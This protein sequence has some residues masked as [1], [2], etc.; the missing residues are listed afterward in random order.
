[1]TKKDL[2][3]NWNSEDFVSGKMAAIEAVFG[4]L[5]S[6]KPY[7][8]RGIS[9]GVNAPTKFL[10]TADLQDADISNVDFEHS[11]FSCSFN[12]GKFK[13]LKF[14]NC[15]FDACRILKSSF[16]QCSF[17]SAR[18]IVNLDDSSFSECDFSRAQFNGR[19]GLEY[20]G[21][22]IVFT[23]CIFSNTKFNGIEIRASKFINCR[24]DDCSFERCDLRGVKFEGNAPNIDQ[25]NESNLGNVTFNGQLLINQ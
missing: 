24:F 21:R 7:D 1:V 20:G 13:G 9:V 3:K 8:L 19:R 14:D 16:Q 12:N 15:F 17:I 5:K 2:Q 10:E 18:L 22:R 25:F 11:T 23:D 6:D 4:Q